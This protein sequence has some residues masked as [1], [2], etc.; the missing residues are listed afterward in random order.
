MSA[1]LRDSVKKRIIRSFC[2]SKT[3]AWAGFNL[4][5]LLDGLYEWPNDEFTVN[6][7][8]SKYEGKIDGIS[9]WMIYHFGDSDSS[10]TS[11]VRE[12]VS[13]VK[14]NTS[15]PFSCY[16]IGANRGDFSLKIAGIMDSI[17]A[18]EQ[19]ASRYSQLR[20]NIGLSRLENIKTFNIRLGGDHQNAAWPAHGLMKNRVGFPPCGSADKKPT[21]YPIE[22]EGS[23]VFVE[24]NG[25]QPPDLIRI[26]GGGDCLA[27]IRW[28]GPVLDS[29]QPIVMIERPPPLEA[30]GVGEAGLRS[31]LYEDAKLYSLSGSARQKD[32]KLDRFSPSARR[33]VCY[34]RKI[35]RMIEQNVCKMKGLRFI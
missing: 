17:V 32:F 27:T 20:K 35:N 6:Y 10:V 19:S 33:I 15:Q 30:A 11:F 1:P 12:I 28:L 23:D 31:A 29:A 21:S 4:A 24:S 22:P 26:N 3:I 25:L 34:P 13:F 18:I 8:G 16:D 9:D 14:Y 2:A 5:P 7:F